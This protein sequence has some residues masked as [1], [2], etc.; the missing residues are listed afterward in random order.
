MT[1]QVTFICTRAGTYSFTV[2][3]GTSSMTTSVSCA[4]GSTK[5]A[6]ALYDEGFFSSYAQMMNVLG[7]YVEGY[8]HL[9]IS[10]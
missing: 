7:V 6:S 8:S 4:K 1:G 5:I 3:A 2:S 9:G 10:K